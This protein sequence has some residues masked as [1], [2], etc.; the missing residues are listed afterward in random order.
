VSTEAEVMRRAAERLQLA[1]NPD[2]TPHRDYERLM[3]DLTW[4]IA[5]SRW[6][7]AAARNEDARVSAESEVGVPDGTIRTNVDRAAEATARAIL[8][9]RP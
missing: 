8:A 9:A 2:V 5:L 3:L 6:L 7:E 4:P 1:L